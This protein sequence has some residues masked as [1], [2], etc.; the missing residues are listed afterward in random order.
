MRHLWHFSTSGCVSS[1]LRLSSL[2]L[3]SI[4]EGLTSNLIILLVSPNRASD[5]RGHSSAPLSGPRFTLDTRASWKCRMESALP[6][7]WRFSGLTVGG[8]K[9]GPQTARLWVLAH[10][11]S[12]P[13]TPRSPLLLCRHAE[14]QVAQSSRLLD[15]HS[16]NHSF[17]RALLLPSQ[18]DA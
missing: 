15:V 1:F 5:I 14:V 4:L 13:L 9:C 7:L 18:E 2:H 17:S 3:P 12:I 16:R 8:L 11:L 6:P 10:Q